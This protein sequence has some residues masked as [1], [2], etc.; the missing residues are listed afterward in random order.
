MDP[1]VARAGLTFALSTHITCLDTESMDAIRRARRDPL[2]WRIPEQ[3]PLRE[4]LSA[5]K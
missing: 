3:K 5:D 4:R 2:W 1:R